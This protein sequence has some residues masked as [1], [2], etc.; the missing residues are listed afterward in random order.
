[1]TRALPEMILNKSYF[2][3]AC[4]GTFNL[5]HDKQTLF[6]IVAI[7]LIA[8]IKYFTGQARTMVIAE[9]LEF[10]TH[11]MLSLTQSCR[12][13]VEALPASTVQQTFFGS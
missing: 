10:S 3:K 6:E 9:E 1:M 11:F 13:L 4:W 8:N 5:R 2:K 12:G 7:I